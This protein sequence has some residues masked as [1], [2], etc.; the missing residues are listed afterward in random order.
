MA[1]APEDED[2]GSG[3]ISSNLHEAPGRGAE[4]R[5][6][7]EG[8]SLDLTLARV[9]LVLADHPS[10]SASRASSSSSFSPSSADCEASAASSSAASSGVSGGS[11]A[12]SNWSSA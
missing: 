1:D 5:P 6:R 4:D 2:E 8:T 9:C 10:S 7:D 11:A 12:G 3:R